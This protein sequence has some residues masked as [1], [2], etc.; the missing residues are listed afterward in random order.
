[1][2]SITTHTNEAPQASLPYGPFRVLRTLGEGGYAKA[3]AAQDIPFP[4]SYT[5]ITFIYY[6][7]PGGGGIAMGK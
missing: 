4:G 3:V 5:S 2:M 6:I 1:M 7:S